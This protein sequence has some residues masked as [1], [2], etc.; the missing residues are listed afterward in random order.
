MLSALFNQTE[1][2]F[3]MLGFWLEDTR[4]YFKGVPGTEQHPYIELDPV[5]RQTHLHAWVKG[6]WNG[7]EQVGVRVQFDFGVCGHTLVMH[8][9]HGAELVDYNGDPLPCI[10]YHGRDNRLCN[11]LT[12]SLLIK[13]NA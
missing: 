10:Y 13:W 7:G 2:K 11:R 4:F 8:V 6:R 5:N 9:N 1:T 12:P 3:D